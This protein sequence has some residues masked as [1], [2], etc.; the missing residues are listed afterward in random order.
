MPIPTRRTEERRQKFFSRCMADPVMVKEFPDE[1]IRGGVC[2]SQWERSVGKTK[3]A[4][5]R[6][7][8]QSKG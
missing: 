4:S 6:L 3:E 8:A 7:A 1:K 5:T 2:K